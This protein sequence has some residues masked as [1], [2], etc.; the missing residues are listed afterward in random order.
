[1][2]KTDTYITEKSGYFTLIEVVGHTNETERLEREA[3]LHL[4][5]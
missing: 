1:M 4:I 2:L 3:G 5:L